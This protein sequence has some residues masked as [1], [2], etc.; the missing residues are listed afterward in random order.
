MSRVACGWNF[1][2]WG[3][4]IWGV[5]DVTYSD[6]VSARMYMTKENANAIIY[7]DPSSPAVKAGEK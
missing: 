3:S 2:G 5:D 1:F 6:G 7:P 4:R